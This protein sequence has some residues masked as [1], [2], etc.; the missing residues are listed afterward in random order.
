MP[1]VQVY[2]AIYESRPLALDSAAK[3]LLGEIPF[4]GRLPVSLGDLYP[5]G[6]GI[7]L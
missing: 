7:H 1:E 6:W 3:A 2:A 5:A 4:R